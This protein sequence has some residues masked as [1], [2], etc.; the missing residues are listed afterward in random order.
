[1]CD[2]ALCGTMEVVQFLV[3]PVGTRI[4]GIL[5][6]VTFLERLVVPCIFLFV[7]SSAGGSLLSWGI[8]APIMLANVYKV[9]LVPL[10]PILFFWHRSRNIELCPSC[11]WCIDVSLV[12]NCIGINID[13]LP[14]NQLPLIFAPPSSTCN[15][16]TSHQLHPA[17]F[18]DT[19]EYFPENHNYN[20]YSWHSS[21]CIMNMANNAMHL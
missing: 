4:L 5:D 17:I 21:L 20:Q 11:W 8:V 18:Q 7:E 12:P 6:V 10:K 19:T 13:A 3:W 16:L 14:L 2:C 15:I 1:M 9:M